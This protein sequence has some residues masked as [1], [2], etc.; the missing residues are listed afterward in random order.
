VGLFGL[1]VERDTREYKSQNHAWG[2]KDH[3]SS[4]SDDINVLERHECENKVGSRDNQSNSGG[5][6]ESY[7]LKQRCG[8]VH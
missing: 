7:G 6:I 3:D 8:V 2:A 5:L 1:T 4:T